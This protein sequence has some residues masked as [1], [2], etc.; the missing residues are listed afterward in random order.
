MQREDGTNVDAAF[1]EVWCAHAADVATRCRYWTRRSDLADEA[2][3]R[4]A[5][6]ALRGWRRDEIANARAWLFRLARNVCID[7]HRERRRELASSVPDITTL[8][9]TWTHG[10]YLDSDPETALLHDE[11]L[12][13][14]GRALSDLPERLRTPLVL[15]AI[16]GLQTDEV[17]ER[18]GLSIHNVRKRVQE[19]K[20]HVRRRIAA[21]SAGTAAPGAG[22]ATA[23]R[24][25][26]RAV[27]IRFRLDSGAEEQTM[28]FVSY[29][30]PG[31]ARALQRYLASY[32]TGWKKRLELA[33]ALCESGGLAE[34]VEQYRRVLA[35]NPRLLHAWLELARALELLHRDNEARDV[36]TAAAAQCGSR[37]APLF[38][39]LRD[40]REED[41]S[42]AP[43][44]PGFLD[45][46]ALLIAR[47]LLDAGRTGLAMSVLQRPSL[48]GEPVVA[49][50]LRTFGIDVPP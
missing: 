14:A 20:Q 36:Y 19:A 46:H 35:R 44:S 13:F 27:P 26:H 25:P 8:R 12:R 28:L 21:Y 29:A 41:I 9:V 24:R 16:D 1:E 38:L 49:T 47:R 17:A 4:V 34:A 33:R 18:L 40:A 45:D 23:A 10:S 39:F 31:D 22:Q 50:L 32:P 30:E 5:V 37:A 42:L 48:C 15:H 3:S 6:L 2:F 11:A 43:V 7:L